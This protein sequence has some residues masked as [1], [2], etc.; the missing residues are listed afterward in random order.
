MPRLFVQS[1]LD[2]TDRA[3]V[4]ALPTPIIAR[5]IRRLATRTFRKNMDVLIVKLGATGDVVR[6]TTLL[7]RFDGRVTWLTASKNKPLLEGLKGT[8]ADLRALEWAE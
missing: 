6:T 1:P 8:S 2:G 4:Y 3:V 5:Y 7:R